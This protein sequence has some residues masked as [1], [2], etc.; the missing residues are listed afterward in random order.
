MKKYLKP[1]L[2]VFIIVLIV[3]LIPKKSMLWDGGSVE[4]KA[5]LYKYTKVHRINN[6]GGYYDGVVIEVLGLKIFDNTKIVSESDI[7][8]I[9]DDGC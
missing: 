9:N 4:Y 1:F 7:T 8:C 5:V 3:L 2:V 6:S